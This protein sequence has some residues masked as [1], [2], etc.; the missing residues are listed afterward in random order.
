M[1]RAVSLIHFAADGCGESTIA[2]RDLIAIRILKIAVEVGLVEGMMPA[3]TPRG[4]AISTTSFDSETTPYGAQSAKVVPNI[5]GR[6]AV[7]LLL[8]VGNAKSGFLDGHRAE[9]AASRNAALRHRLANAIDLRLVKLGDFRLRLDAPPRP[10]RA[11]VALK[12]D[13]YRR[14]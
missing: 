13:P 11:P 8:V 12:P 5:F 7:L 9:R 14:T 1:T 4:L 10:G 6:K 3:T 2:F